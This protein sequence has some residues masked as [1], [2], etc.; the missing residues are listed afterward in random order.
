MTN[1]RESEGTKA[2][3]VSLKPFSKNSET[4]ETARLTDSWRGQFYLHEQRT[5]RWLQAG[6]KEINIMDGRHTEQLIV[7]P[8]QQMGPHCWCVRMSRTVLPQ[9]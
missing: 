3:W 1:A 5:T 2:L 7:W 8:Q 9:C 6:G 4:A